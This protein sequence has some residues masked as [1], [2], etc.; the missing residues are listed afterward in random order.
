M[1]AE[2]RLGPAGVGWLWLLGL[3][4]SVV[5]IQAQELLPADLITTT[6]RLDSV[7]GT[8]EGG[9]IVL[10][11]PDHRWRLEVATA[12][13]GRSPLLAERQGEG[14][15]LALEPGSG[16][17]QPW[18]A[19][20]RPISPSAIRALDD[21]LE[22]WLDNQEDSKAGDGPRRWRQEAR[23]RSGGLPLPDL[24]GLVLDPADLPDAAQ[25]P[26]AAAGLRQRLVARGS[27]RGATGLGLKARWTAEGL[28]LHSNRWPGGLHVRLTGRQA[29]AVPAEAFLPLWPLADFLP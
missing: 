4:L 16:I 22:R 11:G 10:R 17:L 20:W 3:S 26:A 24:E 25:P 23:A 29:I 6:W 7:L 14:W 5:S 28:D 19:P 2:R 13:P 27:G 12:P 21:L 1:G 15:T 8:A 9:M 18:D